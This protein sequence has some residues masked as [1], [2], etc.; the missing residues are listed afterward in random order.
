MFENGTAVTD[1]TKKKKRTAYCRTAHLPHHSSLRLVRGCCF[2]AVDAWLFLYA[3]P[4]SFN[5][6]H[7]SRSSPFPY[8]SPQ[9]LCTLPLNAC[10]TFLLRGNKRITRSLLFLFPTLHLEDDLRFLLL[11]FA[12]VLG[13]I[14]Y[15]AFFNNRGSTASAPL[16]HTAA[17]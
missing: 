4:F 6:I 14:S 8:C 3:P 16:R 7:R 1:R 9:R 2:S 5:K 11:L 13:P 17:T 12:A 15:R 10:T